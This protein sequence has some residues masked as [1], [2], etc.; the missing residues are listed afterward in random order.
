MAKENTFTDL[1]LFKCL[2]NSADYN[3]IS[4]TN[5]KQNYQQ[6][7]HDADDELIDMKVSFTIDTQDDYVDDGVVVYQV[8][9]IIYKRCSNIY[10]YVLNLIAKERTL[11]QTNAE[12]IDKASSK[13]IHCTCMGKG[14]IDYK[15]HGIGGVCLVFLKCS[16][17]NFPGNFNNAKNIL[18]KLLYVGGLAAFVS[19]TQSGVITFWRRLQLTKEI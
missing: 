1:G 6:H 10:L 16:I 4:E 13:Q 14:N 12:D 7:Y 9:L 18:L 2:V 8:E 3:F 5:R 15:L 17:N 19:K 11:K